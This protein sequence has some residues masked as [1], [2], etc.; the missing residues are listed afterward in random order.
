MIRLLAVPI[1]A[2]ALTATA[3]PVAVP[4]TRVTLEPPAGF[5]LAERFP[6]FQRAR[7][8]ASI[9]ITEL[10]AP[11]S[12]IRQSMTRDNL[13][14][15][16]MTLLESQTVNHAGAD[17]L[18][19]KVSQQAQ[20]TLFLKW[21]LVTGDARST[22]LVVGTFPGAA[23]NELGA[24]IRN[25]VLSS[26]LGA[27]LP[28]DH[29]EG[30]SFRIEPGAKLKIAHR[31][32]NMLLLTATGA[33]GSGAPD[34]PVYVVGSSVSNAAI[35]EL[36]AFAHAR[37]NKTA[38]IKDVRNLQGRTIELDGLEA[39]E[40]E[41]DAS[42]AKTGQPMRLY[43]AIARDANGYV[44]AQGLVGAAQAGEYVP[45]FREVTKSFKQVRR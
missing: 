30:L 12:E 13:A 10:P 3:A 6:G 27:A 23:E 14:Q 33:I 43:Q 37:V 22:T 45:A 29:F 32:S 17:A 42:D 19:A 2:G 39:Y 7:D 15:R 8:H 11:A 24:P 41:A 40:L 1:L 16:G 18:L 4:G 31:M 36:S 25:A 5:T 21:M 38:Q 28:K 34:A 35:G 26:T 20:G 9:M 44:I